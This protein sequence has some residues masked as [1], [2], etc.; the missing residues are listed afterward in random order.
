[1]L[2][3]SVGITTKVHFCSMKMKCETKTATCCKQEQAKEDTNCCEQKAKSS[4]KQNSCCSDIV[5]SVALSAE[6]APK[7]ETGKQFSLAPL[8]IQSFQH[9]VTSFLLKTDVSVSEIKQPPKLFDNNF[10]YFL[11]VIKV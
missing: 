11:Q 4:E 10:I 5:K 3:T 1:M 6:Y 8:Y 2:A 7:F 9:E